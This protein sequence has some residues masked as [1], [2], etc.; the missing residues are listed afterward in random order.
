M[1]SRK[2]EREA[3]RQRR[4]EVEQRERHEERRRLRIGFGLAA[5]VAAP[6]LVGIVV[7]IASAGGGSSSAA[8]I[9]TASGATNGTAEDG[10]TGAA[11]PRV[12]DANL[13][14]A[15]AQAGCKLRLGLADEGSTHLQEG[16]STP[17]YGTEPPTSGDHSPVP[18]ADGAYSE[19]PTLIN[20][21]HSLEHGRVEIQYAAGLAE[22]MQLAL[23]GVFDESPG[24]VLFFPNSRM[25]YQVA[26]AAWT[27]FIGC[28][29]Y[30]GAKTLDALRAFRESF[31]GKGPEATP[32]STNA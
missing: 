8:H 32:I 31:R 5:L 3:L 4:V 18:Q 1:A 25:P 21:V 14:Q 19:T 17:K 6:V 2:E 23:K 20:A 16:A 7:L 10:R 27:N 29:E 9:D 15:A 24:G 26:E 22:P 13:K 28:K 12:R 11:P 30:K